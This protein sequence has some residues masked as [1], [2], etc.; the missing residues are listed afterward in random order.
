MLALLDLFPGEIKDLSTLL[1]KKLG[2]YQDRCERVENSRL[3][4]EKQP[5]RRS[6]S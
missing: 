3:M 4:L 2:L 1:L 5:S 6:A